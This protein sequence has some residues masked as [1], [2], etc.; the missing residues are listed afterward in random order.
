MAELNGNYVNE[1]NHQKM[2]KKL[3]VSGLIMMLIGVVLTVVGVIFVVKGFK[4]IPDIVD[5]TAGPESG[6]AKFMNSSGNFILGGF[7]TITGISLLVYGVYAT[8]FAHARE[9]ASFASSSVTP[10][11]TDTV[12]YVAD[13]TSPKIGKALGNI[14]GGVAAGVAAGKAA[15]ANNNVSATEI[16]CAKCGTK[17][18]AGDKFCK[19]CGEAVQTKLV[20][21][22]CGK[23]LSAD[24][25]FCA[26]CGEKTGK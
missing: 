18:N 6:F 26:N 23:E 9:I 2:K 24:A 21:K 8:F 13:S 1:N 11:V 7:L 5:V 15:Q 22:K 16:V 12:N 17:L 4:N 10:V 3:K 20:C 19:S 14:A 25:K